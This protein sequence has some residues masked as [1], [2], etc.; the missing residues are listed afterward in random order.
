M[1]SSNMEHKEQYCLLSTN[2]RDIR[3][4]LSWR[5]QDIDDPYTKEVKVL[6]EWDLE[7]I[8]FNVWSRYEEGLNLRELIDNKTMDY[9][10]LKFSKK[11]DMY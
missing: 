10:D 8:A 1:T 6:D 3:Q 5:F 9:C 4:Y 7:N 2:W 11:E